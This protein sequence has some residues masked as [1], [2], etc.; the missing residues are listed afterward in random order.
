MIYIG[1]IVCKWNG[2]DLSPLSNFEQKKIENRAID[3]EEQIFV[4]EIS[5]NLLNEKNPFK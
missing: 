3:E 1:N 5:Q 4:C 2:M